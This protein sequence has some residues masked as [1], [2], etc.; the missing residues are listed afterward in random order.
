MRARLNRDGYVIVPRFCDRTHIERLI[1]LLPDLGDS[2]GTRTLLELDW[3]RQLAESTELIQLVRKA[4]GGPGL[5]PT[6]AI[7]FD[8]SQAANWV[9]GWHQ[10]E[11]MAMG[12]RS[13]LPGF[14][15]WTEKEGIWHCKPPRKIQETALAVRIHLDDCGPDNGPLRVLPGTHR[16][17]YRSKP[18]G[19]ELERETVLTCSAGDLILMKPLLFHAS[20]KAA[21]PTHRRVIHIEYHD[22]WELCGLAIRAIGKAAERAC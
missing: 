8:K 19:L 4:S 18:T 5:R 11:M 13:R 17:G 10:D 20:G 1:T 6:R 2:G 16:D 9:L 12:Y 7:L 15:R 22:L 21:A 3:A 14:T